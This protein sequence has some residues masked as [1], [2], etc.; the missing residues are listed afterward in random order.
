MAGVDRSLAALA[1]L[2]VPSLALGALL[3]LRGRWNPFDFVLLSAALLSCLV[4]A[5][6]RKPR[7]ADVSSW[8]PTSMTLLM[9]I[10]YAAS[11]P[12]QSAVFSLLVLS[13][14]AGGL[15]IA[16]LTWP[17]R[18]LSKRIAERAL[19]M[20][21]CLGLFVL[22]LEKMPPGR[23]GKGLHDIHA[24]ESSAAQE[25]YADDPLFGHRLSANFAGKFGHPEYAPHPVLV[26]ADGFRGA[27]WPAVDAAL[28]ARVL[29]LG[30]SMVFGLGVAEEETVT[31][32]LR[33]LTLEK[34]PDVQVG[35]FCA[36][37]AGYDLLRHRL[38]IE[39]LQD[40]V[41]PTHVI[42]VFYD[43]NDLPESWHQFVRE[44]DLG[45]HARELPFEKVR[46][47]NRLEFN[48]G[49][50]PARR[51]SLL[52]RKYW[53][54][55]S[56]VYRWCEFKLSRFVPVGPPAPVWNTFLLR[57]MAPAIDLQTESL[58]DMN[59]ESLDATREHCE[60]KSS[61]LLFVR[62][63]AKIQT[64][65]QTLRELLLDAGEDPDLFDRSLP[66]R[67]MVEGALERGI[68]TLDVLPEFE[69]DSGF[70]PRHFREG[71][72]HAG[73]AADLARLL[74]DRWLA[75]EL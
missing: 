20:A 13:V 36:A 3:G 29:I 7:L 63:P 28:D 2:L 16:L 19:W 73:G 57:A 10:E 55:A 37:V 45:L 64:E 27:P 17:S 71:H 75:S 44:R 38:L 8:L 46:R 1:R 23:L 22:A 70:S 4:W 41:R 61:K 40:R 50:N 74:W 72:L 48:A 69:V 31:E 18:R 33:A 47:K 26:N 5:R 59:L 53:Q 52:E 6:A 65:P 21:C 42:V 62:L 58:V 43:G 68:A 25:L 11:P 34:R 67:W 14:G 30:D 51:P 56:K 39:E 12:P 49:S 9:V 32:R 15:A 54:R 24:D 66:G 60:E 35:F